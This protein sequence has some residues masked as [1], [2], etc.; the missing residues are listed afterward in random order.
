MQD[1]EDMVQETLLAAW[2]EPGGEPY[3]DVLL[4]D[5]PDRSAGPAARY[6]ARET[7]ELAFIVDFCSGWYGGGK[8]AGQE[9]SLRLPVP[10]LH[11]FPV[12]KRQRRGGIGIAA[13]RPPGRSRRCR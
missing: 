12:T 3:L 7:I 8:V 2:P 1:A 13:H 10:A 11:A 6:E 4:E 5:I 9:L